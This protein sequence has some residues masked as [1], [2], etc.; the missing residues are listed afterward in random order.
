MM[1][2]MTKYILS[3][4]KILVFLWTLNFIMCLIYT[5]GR[6]RDATFKVLN[7]S[8]LCFIL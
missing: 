7:Y 4:K 2:N 3:E 8:P 1:L 5:K 6:E